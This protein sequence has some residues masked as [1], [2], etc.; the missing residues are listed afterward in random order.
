MYSWQRLLRIQQQQQRF[1]QTEWCQHSDRFVPYLSFFLSFS[2]SLS[3]LLVFLY[4]FS[5]F[6][7]FCPYTDHKNGIFFP[8]LLS[9]LPRNFHLSFS[10]SPSTRRVEVEPTSEEQIWSLLYNLIFEIVI[11]TFNVSGT[12]YHIHIF[13]ISFIIF[14]YILIFLFLKQRSTT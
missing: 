12:C 8:L 9:L 14:V 6:R 7:L 1:Q 11:G 13:L 10:Y 3:I 4:L 5:F 2:F